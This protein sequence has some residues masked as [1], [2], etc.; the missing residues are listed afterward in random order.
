MTTERMRRLARALAE[1]RARAR[2]AIDSGDPDGARYSQADAR[3]LARAL[4]E[5]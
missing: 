3:R 4:A 1:A 5:G 2:D